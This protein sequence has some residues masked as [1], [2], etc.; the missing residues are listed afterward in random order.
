MRRLSLEAK[1]AA[2]ANVHKECRIRTET[3]EGRL[4]CETALVDNLRAENARL[5]AALKSLIDSADATA[6]PGIYHKA[7][8]ERIARAA[9][10]GAR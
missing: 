10:D 8:V 6:D 2:W 5:R 7:V 3:L 4:A 1:R 9:L